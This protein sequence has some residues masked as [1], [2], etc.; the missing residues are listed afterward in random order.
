MRDHNSD[1]LRAAVQRKTE[2]IRRLRLALNSV[3]PLVSAEY[4]ERVVYLRSVLDETRDE[5]DL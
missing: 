5:A 3:I 4:V 2:A 1:M